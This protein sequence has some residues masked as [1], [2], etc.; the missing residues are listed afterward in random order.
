[1]FG[2]RA[3]IEKLHARDLDLHANKVEAEK[4]KFVEA[5]AAW[6][7]EG[8]RRKAAKRQWVDDSARWEKRRRDWSENKERWHA[9][10]TIWETEQQKKER[11][12]LNKQAE[13]NAKVDALEAAWQN[14]QP[15]AIEEHASIVLEASQHDD[16]VPKQWDVQFDEARRLLL[17]DYRLPSPD[18]LPTTK[19]VRFVASTGELKETSISE[20]EKKALFDDLCYQICLR[21]IH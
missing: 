1:M 7:M 20:R 21:T 11:A 13:E 19:S 6:V 16:V 18:D 12:F 9:D 15:D 10:L 2:K 3:K 8:S 4:R 17:V 5:H 14:G